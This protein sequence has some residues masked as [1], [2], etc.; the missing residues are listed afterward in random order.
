LSFIDSSRNFFYKVFPQAVDAE[1]SFIQYVVAIRETE[2]VKGSSK[3]PKIAKYRNIREEG[4]VWHAIIA[5][6]WQ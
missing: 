4:S 2:D 1:T 3:K 5:K 6:I